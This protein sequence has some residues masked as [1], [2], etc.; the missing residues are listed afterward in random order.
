MQQVIPSPGWDS[1]IAVALVAARRGASPIAADLE[2][3]LRAAGRRVGLAAPER[4]A[5]LGEIAAQP[6]AA[7]VRLDSARFLL[8]ERRVGVLITAASPASIARRGLGIDRCSVAAIADAVPRADPDSFRRGIDAILK[9]TSG[10]VVIDADNA[11]AVAATRPVDRA[12]LVLCAPRENEVMRQ[13]AAL[14]GPVVVHVAGGG[15]GH[16]ELRSAG[17]DLASTPVPCIR[18]GA[19][20]ALER[21]IRA[22]MFTVALAFGLGLSSPQIAAAAERRDCSAVPIGYARDRS[23]RVPAL[24]E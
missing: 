24:L 13:H 23:P 2:A 14:G 6:L 21:Q 3:L 19:S 22:R 7:L 20:G 8:R 1:R 9:A 17:T 18:S 5:V 12:R 4:S 10:F 16:I 15:G 11:A